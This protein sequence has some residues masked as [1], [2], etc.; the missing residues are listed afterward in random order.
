MVQQFLHTWDDQ[1]ELLL[2]KSPERQVKFC[3]QSCYAGVSMSVQNLERTLSIA[4][5]R[6]SHC[7]QNEQIV[8]RGAQR[9]HSFSRVP[10]VK[11]M[12]VS[13]QSLIASIKA[14]LQ[15]SKGYAPLAIF[16]FD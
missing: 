11:G 14:G 1:D 9:P 7:W 13:R 8:P 15:L 10:H 6:R 16:L 3:C 5:A 12:C 4:R 2:D